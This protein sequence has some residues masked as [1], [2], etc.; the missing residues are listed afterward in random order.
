[1]TGAAYTVPAYLGSDDTANPGHDY[2]PWWL[3]NLAQDVTGE[4][5]FIEGFVPGPE[6]VR[7]V[8]LYARTVYEYQDFSFYG[9]YGNNEWIEEYTT[10]IRGEP[11]GVTVTVT[12]NDAG[13][14]QHLVVNHRPRSAVLTLARVMGEH[15]AGTP[16]ADLFI[17]S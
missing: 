15:F 14:C 7:S 16:L 17:T 1:M 12:R 8:V 3:D 5:A 6:A 13:Q 4:G 2:Y 11:A 10:K 9:D